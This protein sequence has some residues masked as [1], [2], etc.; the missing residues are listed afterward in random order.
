MAA[1]KTFSFNFAA[2]L[3]LNTSIDDPTIENANAIGDITFSLVD[4]SQRTN[5]DDS[6][7]V[8]GNLA[9][10]GTNDFLAAQSSDNI[11][12]SIDYYASYGG[13]QEL[14]IASVTGSLE[15]SFEESAYI[16][17]IGSNTNQANV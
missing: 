1:G 12:V 16:S 9:T 8:F 10:S 14:A 7:T 5:V 17:L 4:T 13:N 3:D 2:E 6:F 15:S 11:T